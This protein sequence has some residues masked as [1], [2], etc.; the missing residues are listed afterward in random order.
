MAGRKIIGDSL[1]YGLASLL[2]NGSNFFLIPF[3]THYL[4]TSEYGII[5]G[6]TVFSTT[7]MSI[8]C[9][10]L[11]GAVT[12]FYFDYEREEFKIFL[13]TIFVFQILCAIS[14]I[15]IITSFGGG[16]VFAGL[17]K[18]VPYEPYLRYG[19]W[20]AFTGTFSMVPLALFQA[21]S[22]ALAYR[23]CTS[24][25]FVVLTALMFY[26]VVFRKE[27]S[28]GS[29]RASLI[30][31]SIMTLVYGYIV[32]SNSTLIFRFK[33]LKAAL[34]FS[35]PLMI[36]AVFGTMTEMSSKFFI[37]RFVSI[38]ELGIFNVAQQIAAVMLLVSNAINLAWVPIFYETANR[39]DSPESFNLFG[40]FFV[41]LLTVLGLSLSLFASDFVR[42]FMSPSYAEVSSYIPLL[43]LS[44]IIGS[45]YWI[46]LVNP[47]SYSKKTFFLPILTVIS[48]SLSIGLNLALVPTYGVIGAAIATF[49]SYVVLI[50]ATYFVYKKVSNIRY[51][52]FSLNNMIVVAIVVY[53]VTSAVVLDNFLLSLT[54]KLIGVI[55]FILLIGVF[56]IYSIKELVNF[57]KS[58]N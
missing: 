41:F 21:K 48:G 31:N 42:L 55:I 18:K 58:R 30:S 1:V 35:L 51:D 3:Y 10:G 7:L 24:I 15:I 11:N 23:L 47:I 50:V 27:G 33:H 52:F 17:F 40:K 34:I 25:S 32:F 22:K 26:F 46:L 36:Y 45:G 19:V 13:F 49:L 53:M 2:I 16:I 8:F 44:Y 20:I 4:I 37:E 38:S 5:S 43:V 9:L 14:L 28:I 56:K 6:V 39:N 57:V 54:V 29:I 12:R